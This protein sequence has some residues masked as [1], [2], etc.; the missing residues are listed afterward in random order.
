MPIPRLSRRGLTAA[1]VPLLALSACS[2]SN[3]QATPAPDGGI[4]QAVTWSDIAPVLNDK[5]VKCHQQGGVGPFALDSYLNAKPKAALIAAKTGARTMP[6]YLV[7]HDGTCGQFEDAETLTADQI[8]KIKAWAEGGASEGAPVTL[9]KPKIPAIEG[10]TDYKTPLLAPQ[11]AGGALAQYDEYRCFPLDSGLASD[12][13]I[14]GYDV[15]PGNPKIVHHVVV[16]I[17]DPEKKPEMGGGKTNAEIMQAL[18]AQD[19]DR[20]GWPCFGLAG[21]GVEVD[22]VPAVW[23]PGQGPVSYP[24]K[25]GVRQRKTDK[26]VIQLHYNLS[27]PSLKGMTDS[28]TVR[29]RHADTVERRGV[30]LLYDGFL[31]TLYKVDAQGNPAPDFL[32]PGMPSTKYSWKESL[33]DMGLGQIPVP[34]DLVAV[35]PHMHQRGHKKEMAIVKADGTSSCA[36]RVDAWDFNW[37]KFYFYKTPPQ[38]TSETQFQL[39]CDYDT[40]KDANPVMPGWGTRNEMCIAI[41]MFALPPGI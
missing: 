10:G 18:D 40:S 29:F 1:L 11:P 32:P 9:T 36:A 31:Q 25:L 5:C 13:F 2:S 16:F 39:T 41:L 6:P 22:S 37:Q 27:D 3:S 14:T 12:K 8:A 33:A 24:M 21:E 15:L 4:S 28:T 38:V 23:A 19:P 26:V 7:T 20:I 17:I 35:M 30:F 34:L